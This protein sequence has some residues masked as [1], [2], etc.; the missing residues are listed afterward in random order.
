MLNLVLFAQLFVP[1]LDAT[2][3]VSRLVEWL[4]LVATH[5]PGVA[6]T[7]VQRAST[8]TP[9]DLERLPVDLRSL[10]S[11]IRDPDSLNTVVALSSQ[12][13]NAARSPLALTPNDLVG[14][15]SFVESGGR[16]IDVN[17]VLKRGAVLHSDVAMLGPPQGNPK[18]VDVASSMRSTTLFADDG[19]QRG[20][21]GTVAHWH[22]ARLLLDEVVENQNRDELPRPERD[23]FVRLWYRASAAVM[24]YQEQLHA[25]HVDRAVRLFP[26][27]AGILFLAGALHESLAGPRTQYALRLAEL[28]PGVSF[29]VD[30]ERGE[31][32]RAE[33]MF[34]RALEA[35]PTLVEARIRLGRVLGML[36][37]SA[38]AAKELQVAGPAAAG[39]LLQYYASLFLA[40]ELDAVG[41][42]A[43]AARAYQRAAALYPGA[44]SPRLGLRQLAT[45]AGGRPE[46][47][48]RID[49]VL[50]TPL[51]EPGRE[52]PWWSYLS[53]AGR[54]A[55]QL[56]RELYGQ[57]PELSR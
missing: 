2:P 32:R 51:T 18:D 9:G 25:G 23:A 48:P 31:L 10:R 54:F 4:T 14:L 27:D 30:D 13:T 42:R 22:V 29:G 21:V 43:G 19:Q 40:R 12:R 26:R 17:A 3:R 15:R 35:D 24:Q 16:R 37:R 52:D 55:G 44:Q 5:Q 57:M 49:D 56:F 38:E 28:P 39:P 7:A 33:S 6:D 41:D 1:P 45:Q 8:W 11:L 50:S 36:G 20:L 46:G 34:R 53:V 47:L